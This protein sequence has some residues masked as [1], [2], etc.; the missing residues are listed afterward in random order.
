MHGAAIGPDD[1]SRT[2]KRSN[3]L[4][5]YH[6]YFWAC[7]AVNKT[8]VVAVR[9]GLAQPKPRNW[10]DLLLL[11]IDTRSYWSGGERPSAIGP[12]WRSRQRLETAGHWPHIPHTH[13]FTMLQ[14]NTVKENVYTRSSTRGRILAAGLGLLCAGLLAALVFVHAVPGTVKYISF[15][16]IGRSLFSDC[17]FNKGPIVQIVS[18]DRAVVVWERCTRAEGTNFQWQNADG[19]GAESVELTGA[20]IEGGYTVYRAQVS[21]FS[22][23]LATFDIGQGGGRTVQR[24]HALMPGTDARTSLRV[25]VLGDNQDG[26]RVFRRLLERVSEE[27]PDFVLHLGDMVQ[28][29][30]KSYDWQ[31]YFFDPLK[32]KKIT[33]EIPFLITQGNHDLHHGQVAAYFP[34]RRS[35]ANKPSGYY[36]ALTMGPARW[37]VLDANNKDLWQ[38]YWLEEELKS[39]TADRQPFVIVAVHIPPFI[40]FWD[41]QAWQEGE[42]EWSLHVERNM[43]PLFEKYGVDLVLSGHQHN[44]QRGSRNGVTYVISGGGGGLVDRDRVEDFGIYGA[45]V[46]GHHYTTLEVSPGQIRL[47]MRL[48]DGTV[49]DEHTIIRR[50]DTGTAARTHE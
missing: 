11:N 24:F 18:Q 2:R 12:S 44:Y 22:P 16:L 34:T 47:E 40:E 39:Q 14:K 21:K 29:A 49:G 26:Y 25:A 32:E 38:I 3:N 10:L 6:C 46:L 4:C 28:M 27:Q 36:Y 17:S 35:F 45:T 15:W 20:E 9:E 1:L 33:P 19:T 7:P 41:R 8:F 43:V 13:Y 5:I 30:Q 37:V 42:N 31:E 23:G 48:P 50:H